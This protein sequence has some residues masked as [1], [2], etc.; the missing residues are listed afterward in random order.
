MKAV[1][2]T[3]GHYILTITQSNGDV[4]KEIVY[5]GMSGTAMMEEEYI[6]RFKYPASQGF[7][8]NW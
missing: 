6:L 8:I 5:T 2:Y 1:G 7:K 4:V 3:W